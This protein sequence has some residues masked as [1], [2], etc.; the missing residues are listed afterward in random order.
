V[1]RSNDAICV[2]D[3]TSGSNAAQTVDIQAAGNVDALELLSAWFNTSAGTATGEIDLFD[4]T[5]VQNIDTTVAVANYIF[6]TT[7]KPGKAM[8]ISDAVAGGVNNRF[9]AVIGTAGVGNT[10]TVH[11]VY[12]ALIQR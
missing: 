12:R 9:R 2:V 7:L 5:V 3:A 10:S 1:G 4:G 6:N 11:I 8:I